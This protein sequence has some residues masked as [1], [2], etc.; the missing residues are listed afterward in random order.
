MRRSSSDS[1][2]T[3]SGW[4]ASS[5]SRLMPISTTGSPSTMNSHCHPAMPATPSMPSNQPDTGPPMT[6]DT[7]IA[8]MNHAIIRVRYCAG[9][10]VP[11]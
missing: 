4:S 3:S 6:D 8:T 7:G 1:Q 10:Q 11:R 2:D 5:Q 9:N